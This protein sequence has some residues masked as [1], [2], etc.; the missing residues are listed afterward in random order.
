MAKQDSPFPDFTKL[1]AEFQVPGVDM[2][3]AMDAQR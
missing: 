1:F 2:Q 3:A